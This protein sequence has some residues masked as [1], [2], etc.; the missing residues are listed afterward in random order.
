M[1]H[2]DGYLSSELP[3]ARRSWFLARLADRLVARQRTMAARFSIAF[4]SLEPRHGKL[5]SRSREMKWR[6]T[7]CDG[8]F[9]QFPAFSC[10]TSS[11][12]VNKPRFV[13][14]ARVPPSAFP[15]LP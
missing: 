1:E 3:A 15:W 14:V 11:S 4:L 12:S 6:A 9:R 7:K 8:I 2:L 5:F 10:A 13:S